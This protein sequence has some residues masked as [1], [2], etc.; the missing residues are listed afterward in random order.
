MLSVHY[1]KLFPKPKLY[2]CLQMSPAAGLLRHG[3]CC[4]LACCCCRRPILI[5]TISCLSRDNHKMIT[6]FLL[7]LE[8]LGCWSAD[9][10]H[11]NQVIILWLSRDNDTPDSLWTIRVLVW[12]C[13]LRQEVAAAAGSGGRKWR[14][15]THFLSPLML[16][17][18]GLKRVHHSWARGLLR[19]TC[20]WQRSWQKINEEDLEEEDIFRK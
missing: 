10:Y 12:L 15:R 19:R 6:W 8:P 17:N 4:R 14:R 11:V 20:R 16:G 1:K 7:P 3:C 18:M 9:A 5:N 13:L 2:H